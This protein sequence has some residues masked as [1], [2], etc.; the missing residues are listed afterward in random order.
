MN[1]SGTASI[2]VAE[3]LF[4][5]KK[6]CSG[7]DVLAYTLAELLYTRVLALASIQVKAHPN[8]PVKVAI[9]HIGRG[10]NFAAFDPRPHQAPFIYCLEKEGPHSF[11]EFGNKIIF[12]KDPKR[13]KQEFLLD[14]LMDKDF[15][16]KKIGRN[17]LTSEAKAI[18]NEL[19]LAL[20]GFDKEFKEKE[21]RPDYFDL[22]Q[23]LGPLVLLSPKVGFEQ[24][25]N[26]VRL[27]NSQ[28]STSTS[29]LESMYNWQG[30]D[31]YPPDKSLF[32]RLDKY[33]TQFEKYCLPVPEV[34][35]G[36]DDGLYDGSIY[37]T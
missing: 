25:P 18:R 15:V 23:N 33:L 2:S 22:V 31:F 12:H 13:Y 37:W 35:K 7:E 10:V 5:L 34:S 26:L 21:E 30:L 28:K 16:V 9:P 19:K 1:N 20:K 6:T 3:G 11:Y 27:W 14:Y 32:R 8:D 17:V 24:L 36:G 29:N 4:L